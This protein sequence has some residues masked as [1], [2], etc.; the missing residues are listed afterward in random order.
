MVK[1]KGSAEKATRLEKHF[2]FNISVLILLNLLSILLS[3]AVFFFIDVT[4]PLKILL[5]FLIICFLIA[6]FCCTELLY[7]YFDYEDD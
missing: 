4:M 1:G 2:L 6:N 7:R 3:T 5:V